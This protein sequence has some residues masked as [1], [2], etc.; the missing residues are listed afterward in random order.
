MFEL[1]HLDSLAILV[2]EP[3]LHLVEGKGR[4]SLQPLPPVVQEKKDLHLPTP[5]PS[6]KI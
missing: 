3:Q 4:E 2:V 5:F 1:S 6:L